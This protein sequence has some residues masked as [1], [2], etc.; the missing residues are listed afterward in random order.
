MRNTVRTGV[1]FACLIAAILIAALM[2]SSCGGG[3]HEGENVS[4]QVIVES[5]RLVTDKD[6]SC[7]IEVTV[8]NDADIAAHVNLEFRVFD[9]NGQRINDAVILSIDPFDPPVPPHSRSTHR[10]PIS[11]EGRYGATFPPCSEIARIEL[12]KVKATERG[13]CVDLV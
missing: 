5:A 1:T 11:R 7:Q 8:F 9:V 4:S 12:A 13:P 3:C 2:L 10:L 6:G